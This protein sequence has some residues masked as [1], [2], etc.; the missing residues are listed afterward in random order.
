MGTPAGGLSHPVAMFGAEHSES[1]LTLLT[2]SSVSKWLTMPGETLPPR[3]I[4]PR[5]MAGQPSKDSELFTG[6][7]TRV[8][9]RVCTLSAWQKPPYFRSA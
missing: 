9:F 3:R 8:S 4:A 2:C 7:I 6:E 1:G 5:Y